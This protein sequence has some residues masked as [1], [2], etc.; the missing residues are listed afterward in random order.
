MN[1][2]FVQLDDLEASAYYQITKGRLE[3]IRELNESVDANTREM[4]IQKHLFKH[5]WLL[6]PSWE[7]AAQTELMESRV[8]K[9]FDSIDAGLSEEQRN[10]RLDIKYKTTGNKHVIIEL[11]RPRVAVD[12]SE[13]QRQVKKYRGAVLNILKE[14]GKQNEY[15]EFVCVVGRDPKDWGDY[16]KSEEES[17]GALEELKA[18]IVKYDELI[19]N[20]QMAY[21]DYTKQKK[22]VA[23]TFNLIR[24]ITLDGGTL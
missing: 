15:V 13:L 4:V 21:R 1:D 19:N 12:S 16:D 17:R 11:K 14:Q 23:R 9:A 10:G 24:E 5:L 2:I 8:E 7:R 22:N 18:R 6:D 20:A 3:V